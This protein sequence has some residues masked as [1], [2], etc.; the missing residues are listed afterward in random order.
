MP[1]VAD[2]VAIR[3]IDVAAPWLAE[4]GA[5]PRGSRLVAAAMSRV[6]VR[7]VDTRAE[8]S[9]ELE[10]E[11]VLTPL[12]EL[13]DMNRRPTCPTASATHPSPPRRSGPS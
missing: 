6:V 3:W 8:L 1:K 5:D 10:F 4:V 11:A 9:H 13:A 12:D 2:D 7:F